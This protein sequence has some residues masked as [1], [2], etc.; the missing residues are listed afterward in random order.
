[1]TSRAPSYH[2]HYSATVWPSGDFSLSSLYRMGRFERGSFQKATPT[3]QAAQSAL[4]LL[5]ER[6]GIHGKH[7]D[8]TLRP[9]AERLERIRTENPDAYYTG[10]AVIAGQLPPSALGLSVVTKPHSERRKP[11]QRGSKGITT[12]GRRMVKSCVAEISRCHHRLT[13]SFGT[14]TV[15]KLDVIGRMCLAKAWPEICRQF[16]QWIKRKLRRAGVDDRVVII[17]EIQQ[18]RLE[19]DGEAYPHLHWLSVGKTSRFDKTWI[20]G[21]A[22]L[23]RQWERLLRRFTGAEISAGQACRLECPRTDPRKELGKYMSKGGKL[24]RRAAEMGQTCFLPKAW[25]QAPF[26]LRR[27]VKK[28]IVVLGSR[29]AHALR[30][31]LDKLKALGIATGRI[32]KA[33]RET[34]TGFIEIEMG[35]V[36]YFLGSDGFLRFLETW[37]TL[38]NVVVV[39]FGCA[40]EAEAFSA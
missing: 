31:N 14:A 33:E 15:P 11:V 27:D 21:A 32:V 16:M 22:D 19:R 4:A 8:E 3:Q 7:T 9:H 20:I 39:D 40:N 17:S 24:I 23:D 26:Q 34:E 30:V 6:Y 13:L 2:P 29:V 12:Y 37:H 5:T 1:M 25:W 35:A 10:V 38:D 36:G 18:S 28:Q